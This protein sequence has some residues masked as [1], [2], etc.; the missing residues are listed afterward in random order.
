MCPTLCEPL[1][2]L[3]T[4]AA[5]SPCQTATSRRGTV[6]RFGTLWTG[7]RVALSDGVAH[8]YRRLW[9]EVDDVGCDAEH[10]GMRFV[11]VHG[12]PAGPATWRGA[13]EAL[14]QAGHTVVVPDLRQAALSGQPAAMVAKVV[15]ECPSDTDVL[16]GHS[17]AGLLLPAI[18]DLLSSDVHPRLVFVDGALPDCEGE[19]KRS[20]LLV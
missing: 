6:T 15:A 4:T 16:V 20:G 1:F 3:D 10:V 17:G 2:S 5:K 8:W 12:P 7:V 13:A 19:A 18:A 14:T 9:H 11:L